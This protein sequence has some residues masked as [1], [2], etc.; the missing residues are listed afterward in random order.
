[1]VILYSVQNG[2]YAMPLEGE[3]LAS[4]VVIWDFFSNLPSRSRH[5]IGR[6]PIFHSVAQ[7]DAG[8]TVTRHS[9][10]PRQPN[11]TKTGTCRCTPSLRPKS[12]FFTAALQRN[13]Q[14]LRLLQF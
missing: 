3:D 6:T 5:A 2:G 4:P 9:H 12:T 7:L 8:P 11:S 1:V 14:S 13:Y 10:S